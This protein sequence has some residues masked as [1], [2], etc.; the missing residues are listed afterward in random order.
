MTT[1]LSHL[2]DGRTLLYLSDH[3]ASIYTSSF[4]VCGVK[5]SPAHIPIGSRAGQVRQVGSRTTRERTRSCPPYRRLLACPRE[6][7]FT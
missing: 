4:C 1:H 2:S 5:R 7:A 3:N 6:R